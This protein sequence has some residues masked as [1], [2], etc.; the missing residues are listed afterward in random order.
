M[1][2]FFMVMN[3]MWIFPSLGS[4]MIFVR[5]PV[6]R[7]DGKVALELF[8]IEHWIG[9]AI[10]FLQLI[11]FNGWLMTRHWMPKPDSPRHIPRDNQ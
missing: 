9:V 3:C 11:F 5:N 1:A 7:V 8:H 10:L 6:G 4:V 2:I